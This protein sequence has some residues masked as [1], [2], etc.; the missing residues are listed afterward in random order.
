MVQFV[1]TLGQKTHDDQ[2]FEDHMSQ[3]EVKRK[4]RIFRIMTCLMGLLK[5]LIFR[6]AL[7]D[8]AICSDDVAH[9]R[10]KARR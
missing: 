2:E 4:L 3:P 6:C 7:P 1:R 8:A 5:M 9:A 10:V